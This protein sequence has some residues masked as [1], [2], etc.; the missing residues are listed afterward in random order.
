MK[1][2]IYVSNLVAATLL[3]ALPV[4][5]SPPEAAAEGLANAELKSGYRF[6]VDDL[7]ALQ[8]AI[9]AKNRH[10]DALLEKPGTHGVGVSWSDDGS[11]VVKVF[12][13][14]SASGA[15]IPES[16]DGIPVDVVHAGRVYAFNVDCENRGLEGCDIGQ[17]TASADEQPATPRDW[18][19]RPVPIGISVGHVDVTA[20]TLACRVTRGCHQYALSNAHVFADENSGVAGDHILQPGP[21]DG[22]IDPDDVIG[23]LFESVPIVMGTSNSVRNLVDAAIIAT[24]GSLV[25]N[26]TRTPSYGAPRVDTIAPELGMNVKKYGRSSWETKA[27]IEI[28]SFTIE[29]GYNS[30]T[31]RFIDQIVIRSPDP[32]LPFSSPGDSGALIV[33]DGGDNDR[34]PVG[35]LFAATTDGVYTIANPIDDV[36]TALDISIDGD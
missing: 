15:A 19:P 18:H 33:A 36:L 5:A 9:D 30:G 11:P 35:L 31:A 2:L 12:V 27:Y 13:D 7:P 10:V 6:Q 26:A 3:L 21:N 1:K 16:I 22:G 24:D 4:L 14:I 17:A 29:V 34:R 25:G 23:T 32:D 20:G 8:K 28:V